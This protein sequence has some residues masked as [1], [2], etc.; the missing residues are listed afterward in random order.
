M[1]CWKYCG[2]LFALLIVSTCG[3]K[4]E[5]T[6]YEFLVY[7]KV[8]P[9]FHASDI[10]LVVTDAAGNVLQNF[11]IGSNENEFQRTLQVDE[12]MKTCHIHLG[13]RYDPAGKTFLYSHLDVQNGALVVFEPS[14][15]VPTGALLKQKVVRV[16]GIET[17]DSMGFLGG[18][19]LYS[20]GSF[21]PEESKATVTMNFYPNQ[22]AVVHGRANGETGYRYL[23]ISDSI[24]TNVDWS[25]ETQWSLFQPVPTVKTV[26]TDAALSPVKEMLV[27]AI[28]DD[29]EHFVR[30]GP[31]IHID[32]FNLQFIQPEG[33]PDMLRI[34][35]NGED[36]GTERIFHPGEPLRFDM[37][38]MQIGNIS[39]MPGKGFKIET[40]GNIDMLEVICD[41][42][43]YYTWKIQGKPESFK[44]ATLPTLSQLSAYIPMKSSVPTPFWRFKVR[45]HQFGEHDYPEVRAGFPFR[46]SDLFA[47]AQSGYFMLEK[48]F[49]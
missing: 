29:F 43:H 5:K 37:A 3:C 41:E 6:Q 12:D 44:E 11:V 20:Y 1:K 45:A 8:A 42:S 9:G 15:F 19:T 17:L 4:K 48:D 23:Y 28:T 27:E 18:E 49:E 39:S 30:I 2:L 35:L 24:M 26:V 38:D 34:R 13:V 46:S 16:Y 14:W 36:Y 40:G 7:C 33:V 31:G 47:V 21:T 25:Y 10:G 22:G 32:P